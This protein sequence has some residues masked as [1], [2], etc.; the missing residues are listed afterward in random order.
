[1]VGDNPD[2]VP[3]NPS[4]P[5]Q[6]P[7]P[8][9]KNF[10]CPSCGGPVTIRYPGASLSVVCSACHSVIDASNENY[11]ILST[12]FIKKSDYTP[13]LALGSRGQLK[14]RT[15][16]VIGFLV[17]ADVKSRYK[18]SEYLLFNPYYGFRWLTEDAG[19]WNFITTIKRKPEL[20]YDDKVASLGDRKYRLFN[21]GR[22][23]VKFVLGEFYWRVAVGNNV[24][25]TDYIDP[26]QMLS[27]ESD[28]KETV[29]SIGEYITPQEVAAG[30]K[31]EKQLPLA[32]GVNAIQPD[33]SL[34][35]W[36]QMRLLLMIFCGIIT[37]AQVCITGQSLNADAMTYSNQFSRF[38]KR[39]P[40]SSSIF[41][42]R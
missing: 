8:R 40:M 11:R 37:C 33:N 14:G 4:Q 25:M 36:K 16:E 12:L 34:S 2:N 22:T 10:A 3:N 41:M 30:F 27:L 15:W 26:P 7:K 21:S 24:R 5:A 32:T 28:D 23:E 39:R 13:L 9:V 19:H 31:P 20:L 42:P 6:K 17:R 29:W 18:W 38:S 35:L 1:M